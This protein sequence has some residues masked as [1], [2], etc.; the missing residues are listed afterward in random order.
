LGQSVYLEL[1]QLAVML[2]AGVA[3]DKAFSALL[4]GIQKNPF[5]AKMSKAQRSI[6]NG[7]SIS[8]AMYKQGLISHA[9]S[10]LL[11][12]GEQPGKT[13]D[14]LN[15]LHKLRQDQ[16][17]T[18]GALRSRL[19]LPLAIL[20]IG[21]LAGIAI[22]VFAGNSLFSAFSEVFWPSAFVLFLIKFVLHVF[23]M[24]HSKLLSSLWSFPVLNSLFKQSDSYV[25]LSF[26]QLFYQPLLR[27]IQA[28]LPAD[29]AIKN[30]G[31]LLSNAD[32]K[33][34]VFSAASLVSKGEEIGEALSLQ[35]L[36]LSKRL[37]GVLRTG[38]QSGR[39][40]QAIASELNLQRIKLQQKYK[41]ICDW[42][43]R[44]A[45]VVVLVV[46]SGFFV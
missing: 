2:D 42:W 40:D 32:F 27:Q 31:L 38:N 12:V 34:Q 35:G 26:I 29:K 4:K 7:V 17:M 10:V 22:K 25:Q 6:S 36:V 39:F 30:C 21:A 45:Y 9:D 13:A 18:L 15:L 33:R 46:V 43:P 3:S 37:N 1:K 19:I 20:T 24:D 8:K 44:L 5:R 41:N 11:G 28:G 23:S 16:I 14:A